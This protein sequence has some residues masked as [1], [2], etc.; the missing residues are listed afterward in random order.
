MWSRENRGDAD[1][2][3]PG[4]ATHPSYPRLARRAGGKSIPG[5]PPPLTPRPEDGEEMALY[6]RMKDRQEGHQARG[7]RRM[8]GAGTTP[9][10][11]LPSIA[12]QPPV[13]PS[14]PAARARSN[15]PERGRQP[16]PPRPARSPAH[17][18]L[19]HRALARALAAHHGDLRQLQ[20]A[21]LSQRREGVLQT[22]H[23][24]DQLLHLPVPHPAS[25]AGRPRVP[26]LLCDLAGELGPRRSCRPCRAGCCQ[27]VPAQTSDPAAR[28]P[29]GS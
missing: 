10:A 24:R 2:E 15:G 27:R 17:E 5:G 18:V 11:A 4:R 14:T 1:W 23:Q 12:P 21:A 20:Q 22:V 8:P 29:L 7:G 26:A 3:A 9:P 19:E 6:R 25:V 16:R 13:R 28:Q